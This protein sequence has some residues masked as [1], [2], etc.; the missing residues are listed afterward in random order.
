MTE[1]HILK[2]KQIEIA[3]VAYSS[4]TATAVIT[5]N[6]SISEATSCALSLRL[7]EVEVFLLL[8]HDP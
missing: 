7:L 3:I 5:V 8:F 6:N 2:P 1:R 4:H